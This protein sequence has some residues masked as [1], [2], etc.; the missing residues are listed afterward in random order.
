M[1]AGDTIVS[2]NGELVNNHAEAVAAIDKVQTVVKLVVLGESVER[3]IVPRTGAHKELVGVTLCNHES[4]HDGAGVRI[5]SVVADGRA[6]QAGLT[7]GD[8]LL[9]VNGILC[10]GH[11]QAVQVRSAAC[12]RAA[13]MSRSLRTQELR[14]CA[15]SLMHAPRCGGAQLLERTASS[16]ESAAGIK[17]V[18]QS[19][20]AGF[21]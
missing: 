20:Y 15:P 10:T 5:H 8:T 16:E 9:S 4:V 18:V 3:L 21:L 11:E 14:E 7:A 17:V 19:K 2:V 13:P 12:I 1:R 6:A